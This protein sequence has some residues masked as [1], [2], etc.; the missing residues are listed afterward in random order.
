MTATT[1]KQSTVKQSTVVQTTEAQAEP[2]AVIE[3][4]FKEKW[5]DVVLV[6]TRAFGAHHLE[7]IENAVQS[8]MVKALVRWTA[9][10]IPTN[11]S[12]WLLT[13]AK[14]E[15]INHFRRAQ[16]AERKLGDI[17]AAQTDEAQR[18]EAQSGNDMT[19]PLW[20]GPLE[21]DVIKMMLVCCHPRLK[22]RQSVVITLRLVCG[23]T[24]AEIAGGLLS[25]EEAVRKLLTRTKAKIRQENIP[26]ELP[27]LAKL[28]DRIGRACQIIYLLFNEG[29][30]ASAGENLI[31]RDLC[32]EAQRLIEILLGSRLDA[33]GPMLALAALMAFQA[34]RLPARVDQDGRLLR[35]HEQDRTRWDR[36]QIVRGFAYLEQSMAGDESTKYH[37]E[38]AIA[39]CHAM[40]P[41]YEATDW[42]QIKRFYDDLAERFPSPIVE[43]NRSVALLMTDG[44]DAAIALLQPLEGDKA[45]RGN[46]LLPALLGDFHQRAGRKEIAKRYYLQALDLVQTVPVRQFLSEKLDFT[47]LD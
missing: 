47:T 28:D 43:L 17:Y 41:S 7:E 8:A 5:R 4:F 36:A 24:P 10:E 11:P 33:K 45:L 37:L 13:V 1:G 22:P 46:H 39:A 12:G 19:L 32:N 18:Y 30:S 9:E 34:A 27:P 40:A 14:N 2:H 6:L 15:L 3:T 23:L 21:D 31:R 38:A 25:N 44:P 20:A 29:Y 35:L 42:V 16:V 26:F